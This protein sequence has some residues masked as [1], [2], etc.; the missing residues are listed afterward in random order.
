MHN[1]ARQPSIFFHY[2]FDFAANVG[3]TIH[4]IGCFISD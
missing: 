3:R 1:N 2:I 4:V